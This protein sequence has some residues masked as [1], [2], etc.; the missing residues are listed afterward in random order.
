MV[1]FHV[2]ISSGRRRINGISVLISILSRSVQHSMFRRILRP[3]M[4]V[5]WGPAGEQPFAALAPLRQVRF[6]VFNSSLQC[7][8]Q[9]NDLSPFPLSGMNS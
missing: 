5:F 1:G 2:E 9:R 4:T 6:R 7:G 3:T 8:T